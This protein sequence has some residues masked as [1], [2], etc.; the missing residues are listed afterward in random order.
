MLIILIQGGKMS[1]YNPLGEYLELQGQNKITLTFSKIEDIL[2]FK[3]PKSAREYTAWWSG[4]AEGAKHV[5]C[6][7]WCNYGYQ[8]ETL[9]LIDETVIFYK[10]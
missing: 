7:V 6:E 2:G 10:L 1:K 8:V 9:N 3:L 5:Q 4:T